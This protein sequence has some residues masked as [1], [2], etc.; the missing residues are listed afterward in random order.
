MALSKEDIRD[1]QAELEEI[2]PMI[3]S[4]SWSLEEQE[5]ISADDLQN[6]YEY[7]ADDW[8][9]LLHTFYLIVLEAE[10]V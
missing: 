6:L 8:F 4:C 2:H 5:Y 1:I 10:G 7:Q 9:N 3:S